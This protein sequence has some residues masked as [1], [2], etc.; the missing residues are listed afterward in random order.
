MS[1]LIRIANLQEHSA[2]G[3]LDYWHRACPSSL[4]LEGPQRLPLRQCADTGCAVADLLKGPLRLALC[5]WLPLEG[6]SQARS[7]PVA[8]KSSSAMIIWRLCRSGVD[9]TDHPSMAVDTSHGVGMVFVALH[10]GAQE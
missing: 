8:E 7:V 6:P 9:P 10:S 4:E 5:Q 3:P 2:G 1:A